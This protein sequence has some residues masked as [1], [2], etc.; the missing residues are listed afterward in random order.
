VR[1]ERGTLRVIYNEKGDRD[2]V[3][4]SEIEKGMGREK[5]SVREIENVRLM[6]IRKIDMGEGGETK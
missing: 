5:W 1:R 3:G 4:E 6:E 2:R